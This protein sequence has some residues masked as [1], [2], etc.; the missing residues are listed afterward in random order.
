MISRSGACGDAVEAARRHHRV[1]IGVGEAVGARIELGVRLARQLLERI[2][3]GLEVAAH[4]VGVDQAED[5]AVARLRRGQAGDRLRRGERQDLL[6]R[7]RLG[8]RLR[9]VAVTVAAACHLVD[10]SR[11]R[12]RLRGRPGAAAPPLVE[13]PSP[14]RVDGGG[15]FDI[16]GVD[17][18]YEREVVRQVQ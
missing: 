3:L 4:A 17:L 7:R 1:E 11:G 6:Q 18:V 13:Q 14:A 8:A 5:A 16:P 15:I 12:R 9:T 10:A 2:E